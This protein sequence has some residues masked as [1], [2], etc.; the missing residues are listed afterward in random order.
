LDWGYDEVSTFSNFK[1]CPSVL[2]LLFILK[3]LIGRGSSFVHLSD[4]FIELVLVFC[5]SSFA[6]NELQ[7]AF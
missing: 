1:S 2:Q 6:F 4:E 5:P 3:C 7:I